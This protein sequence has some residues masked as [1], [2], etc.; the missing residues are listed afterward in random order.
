MKLKPKITKFEKDALILKEMRSVPQPWTFQVTFASTIWMFHQLR[1]K[2]HIAACL[3]KF[4]FFPKTDEFGLR[5]ISETKLEP[6]LS[7]AVQNW[8]PD[9]NNFSKL[10]VSSQ[11]SQLWN[12]YFFLFAGKAQRMPMLGNGLVGEKVQTLKGHSYPISTFYKC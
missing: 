8:V 10:Q 3:A 9:L 2:I 1:W 4:L 6:N 11:P 12:V 7:L 5:L